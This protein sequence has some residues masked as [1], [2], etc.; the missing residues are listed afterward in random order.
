MD[1]LHPL[2]RFVLTRWLCL[3]VLLLAGAAALLWKAGQ[4]GMAAIRLHDCAGV[5]RHAALVAFVCATVG[6]LLTEDLLRYYGK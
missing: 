1:R 3:C 4:G 5:F 2:S 6:S